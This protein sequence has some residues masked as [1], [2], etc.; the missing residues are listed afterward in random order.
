MGRFPKDTIYIYF[1]MLNRSSAVPQ[2]HKIQLL[3][4]LGMN[5]GLADGRARTSWASVCCQSALTLPHRC[6]F[7]VL[8]VQSNMSVH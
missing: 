8:A 1:V 6:A 5:P 2:C 4:S 7:Y 3:N